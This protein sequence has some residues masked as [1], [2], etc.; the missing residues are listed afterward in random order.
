MNLPVKLAILASASIIATSALAGGVD[1]VLINTVPQNFVYV[2]GNLG[3]AVVATPDKNL[4]DLPSPGISDA[5]HTTGSFAA[6]ANVGVKHAFNPH[7]LAG[8]ELGW[9]YNGYSKYTLTYTPY[10]GGGKETIEVH[11][12]DLNLLATGTYVFNNGFNLFGK[13]GLASVRQTLVDKDASGYENDDV[14]HTTKILPMAAF[15]AGYQVKLLNFYLQY[16]H[17]FGKDMGNVSDI[18]TVDED[19]A[20]HFKD[21]ASV[22]AIK[23]GVAVNFAI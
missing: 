3:Y 16:S 19:N 23:A 14:T 18:A 13:A 15:G 2:G 17:I 11:S 4:V 8:A 22:N 9:D 12:S 1:T 7:V 6:G 20:V 5:S 21:V 10:F